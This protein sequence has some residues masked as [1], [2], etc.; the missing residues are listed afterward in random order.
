[1]PNQLLLLIYS[2]YS[3]WL[4]MSDRIIIIWIIEV[5]HFENN[6]LWWV[7]CELC[8]ITHH[9]CWQFQCWLNPP[10]QSRNKAMLDLNCPLTFISKIRK[11]L[12]RSDLNMT[13]FWN[14]RTAHLSITSDARSLLFKIQQMNSRR[15]FSR[16]EG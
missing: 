7:Q 3:L 8:N 16:L 14:W 11:I 6:Q 12:K 13:S 4:N 10:M 1:M 5:L 2:N 9:I 15:N